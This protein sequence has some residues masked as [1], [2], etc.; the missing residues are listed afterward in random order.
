MSLS[1]TGLVTLFVTRAKHEMTCCY[2]FCESILFSA[3]NKEAENILPGTQ[4]TPNLL[5]V[6]IHGYLLR[7]VSPVEPEKP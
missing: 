2:S 3:I 7:D 5:D 4:T 1:F 6:Y